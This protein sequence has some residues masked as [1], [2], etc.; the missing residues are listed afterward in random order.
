MWI[1]DDRNIPGFYYRFQDRKPFHA[2]LLLDSRG[3]GRL[4]ELVRNAEGPLHDKLDA[5]QRLSRSEATE[6]RKAFAEI[7]E[8]LRSLSRRFEAT[9]TARMIS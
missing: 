7:R 6:L 4:H 3:G 8:W 9:H 1:T 2:L 5:K